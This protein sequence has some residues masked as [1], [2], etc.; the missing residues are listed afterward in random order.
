MANKHTTRFDIVSSLSRDVIITCSPQCDIIEA[1]AVAR[2][3]LGDMIV[4]QP[5]LSLL[6]ESSRA[7]GKRFLEEL[8]KT[9]EGEISHP[10]ELIFHVPQGT[11]IAMS[12]RGGMVEEGMVVVGTG[13]PPDLTTIYYEV[14]AMNSELTNLVR[15]I[16]KEQARLSARLQNI[17]QQKGQ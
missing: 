17:L 3:M 11:P 9:T 4:N 1:N 15:Q 10:W 7:K 16:S 12:I 13:E 8:A 14:L 2:R 5:F 6:E